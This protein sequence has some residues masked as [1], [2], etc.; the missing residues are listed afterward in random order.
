M[1]IGMRCFLVR[2][3]APF[4]SSIEKPY[5][6]EATFHDDFSPVRR[7]FRFRA[8]APDKQ[9]DA[10]LSVIQ[11]SDGPLSVPEIHERAAPVWA[12]WASPPFIAPS[13]F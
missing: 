5:H 8:A 6:L 13:N 12:A 4:R 2:T 10:I 1:A 9:R 11:N 3:P 7:R